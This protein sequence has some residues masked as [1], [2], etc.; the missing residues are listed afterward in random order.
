MVQLT[1]PLIIPENHYV[2]VEPGVTLDVI[3]KA[4]ILS[5]SA[6]HFSGNED[7]PILVHSSDKS[8]T[9]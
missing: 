5:Y 8:P 2:L 3:N 1:E 4:F 6:M 9:E 7:N